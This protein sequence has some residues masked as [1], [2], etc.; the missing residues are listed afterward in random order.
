MNDYFELGKVLKPQGIKGEV[1]IEAYTDDLSRFSYLK[2]VFIKK[3][4]VMEKISVTKSRYDSLNAYLLLEGVCDRNDAEKL[5]GV[6]L[7]IDRQNAAKLPEGS[8]YIRDLI[9]LEVFDEEGEKYGK[10]T[11]ILQNGSADVYVVKGEKGMMFPSVEGVILSRDI[12]K[13][14]MVVCKKRLDEVCIYDV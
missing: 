14:K 13:G 1:K 3:D 10:V 8:Y 5:R 11:D 4:G 7:Y 6:Y 12:E 2:Y 9:G